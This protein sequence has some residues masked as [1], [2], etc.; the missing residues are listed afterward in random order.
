MDCKSCGDTNLKESKFCKKCGSSLV[1]SCSECKKQINPD[2]KFCI[3][4]G[5]SI[6]LEGPDSTSQVESS[7][8]VTQHSTTANVSEPI[9]S[10]WALFG[11]I[12]LGFLVIFVVLL[13]IGIV[14]GEK[15]S[16]HHVEELGT[17]K[18]ARQNDPIAEDMDTSQ[19]SATPTTAPTSTPYGTPEGLNYYE[20]GEQYLWQDGKYG[21]AVES[22]TKYI[23]LN[24][25]DAKGYEK[26]GNS[27]QELRR[28]QEALKD[29][30]KAIE[31]N[32]ENP[33]VY[34]QR[35]HVHRKSG[36]Y[37]NAIK[38]Y[39]KHI[40]LDPSHPWPHHYK[41]MTYR[42]IGQFEVAI[43]NWERYIE[44]R[45]IESADW[46]QSEQSANAYTNIGLAYVELGQNQKAIE[47]FD[48]A[49]T[50]NPNYLGAIR[51]KEKAAANLN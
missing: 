43:Q 27:Y 10:G 24:P 38:D 46:I 34:G 23:N 4:C 11:K 3:F 32:P 22:F 25:T 39:D 26:R 14:V 1:F 2:S 45:L 37:Q 47:H 20:Q 29:Y 18:I 7:E 12:M 28:Y 35:G 16:S 17:Q 13:T 40:E 30:D 42:D 41:G 5:A 31:L 49:L 51:G 36:Q 44:L 50:I 8:S 9:K 19:E 6:S 21:K 33:D 15:E 48:K